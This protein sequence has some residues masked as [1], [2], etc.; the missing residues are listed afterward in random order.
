MP[1]AFAAR[2]FAAAA[3][4][5]PSLAMAVRDNGVAVVTFDVPDAKMNT[6]C[7]SLTDDFKACLDQIDSDASIKS[8]VLISGKSDNFIAGADIGQLSAASSEEEMAGLSQMGQQ[9]LQRMEDSKKPFVAAINGACLGGGLEVA[10][11]AHYRIATE[12]P[13]TVLALP[14][15]M[16]GLLPGAGGTQRLPRLIGLQKA[17]PLLLTGK[18]VRPK[19]AKRMGLVDGLADP[20]AL[21]HA[22]VSAAAGLADGSTKMPP[23]RRKKKALLD[24]FLEDTPVGR[25]VVFKKAKES[26]DKA[27]GGHYPAPYEIAK[28]VEAGMAGG[29]AKGIAAESA[30]FGRLGMT[31]ESDSLIS[32]FYGQTALKKSRFGKPAVRPETVAVIG[33]GLMGAGIAQVTAQKAKCRVLLKDRDAASVAKGEGYVKA[34]LDK[35]VKKRALTAYQRDAITAQVVGLSDADE[36]WPRHVGQADLVI[37]AVFED[38]ALKHTIIQQLEQHVAEDCVIATNTSAIPIAD[39]AA[40][41]SRPQNV[42]GMHYFSPVEKMPLLEIITHEGTSDEATRIANDVGIRQ[43]KTCIVVKDVP[44]FYVNRC[45]GP[46]LAESM[47]LC[48]DGV[49]LL[50]LDNAMKKFGLPVGPITLADEVGI[51]VASHVGVFLTQHLGSRMLGGNPAVM[52]EMVS[53][54]MLGKKTGAGFFVHD[55]K[56]KGAAKKVLN[57]EAEAIVAGHVKPGTLEKVDEFTIQQRMI[58]RFINEAV[59]CLQDGIIDSAQDGDMGAIFG[60]GFP[61][62]HGGPFRYVDNFGVAKYVAMMEGFAAQYGEQFTPC[63]MLKE[64]AAE[65]KK[66]RESN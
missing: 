54:G 35:G 23:Q 37:E 49:G 29:F 3:E 39:I 41:A 47:A 21:E 31:P 59:L 9:L 26:V 16:L 22:A 48:A 13:K 63:D 24:R 66:F 25:N 8:V 44:G 56:A 64:Y 1:P 58:C 34:N 62:F 38:L 7:E 12:H 60:I 55:P 46:F 2:S 43:G 36:S 53:K 4:R 61:P 65:N 52:E 6:L 33:A 45:L 19:Q 5:A 17:L 40:G 30:G 15:V 32:I 10:L 51:D 42:V 14:E 57:K 50:E 20:S 27:S 11:A 28:V 18:N